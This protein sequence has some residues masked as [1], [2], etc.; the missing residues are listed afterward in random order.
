MTFSLIYVDG[1]PLGVPW[2]VYH[3]ID[4]GVARPLC[5]GCYRVSSSERETIQNELNTIV[6][7]GMVELSS[8]SLASLVVLVTKKDE[9][10]LFGMHYRSLNEVTRKNVDPMPRIDDARDSL[11]GAGYFSSL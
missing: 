11:R 2:K 5:Q 4:P 6:P 3:M 10:V 8:G 9:C 7:K 1:C